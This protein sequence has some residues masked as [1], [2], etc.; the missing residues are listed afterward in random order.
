MGY[1]QNQTIVFPRNL[2]VGTLDSIAVGERQA[3][4]RAR[5][6]RRARL[7]GQNQVVASAGEPSIRAI[8]DAIAAFLARGRSGEKD[9]LV[10]TGTAGLDRM[11]DLWFGNVTREADS[12]IPALTSTSLVDRWTEALALLL[13]AA[14]QRFVDRL[15]GRKLSVFEVT[16]LGECHVAGAVELLCAQLRDTDWL[17]RYNAVRSLVRLGDRRGRTCLEGALSDARAAVRALA[18]RG[19]SRWDPERA[20]ALYGE[21]LVAEDVTPL[22]RQQ[23]EWAIGELTSGRVVHD[24]LDPI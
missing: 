9:A 6:V 14:P 8:D 23:T 5:L 11:L 10:A 12:P 24:P 1:P 18:I 20:I 21:L 15:A 13:P 19:V 16:L 3:A 7:G 4:D 2:A 22:L 17:I